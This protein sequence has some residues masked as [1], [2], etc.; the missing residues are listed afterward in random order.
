MFRASYRAFGLTIASEVELPELPLAAD[1]AAADV[2]IRLGDTPLTLREGNPV[3][4]G[5]SA[6]PG[7]MLID[8][9]AARF[10][11]E[12]GADILVEFKPR[13]SLRDT[14]SYLLGS[15]MGAIIHQRG[16]LPLHANVIDIGGAAVAFA[17]DTGAGKSTLADFFLR[18][19][20]NVLSDDVCVVTFDRTG[21]PMAWPGIP[22]IKLWQDALSVTG[23]SADGLERVFDEQPK[24]SVPLLADPPRAPVPLRSVYVLETPELGAASGIRALAGAEA[25]DRIRSNIYRFEYATALGKSEIQFSNLVGLL[26]A[27]RIFD[28]SRAWGFDVFES[29]AE[30]LER[31]F[32]K[33][34]QFP[35]ANPSDT[36]SA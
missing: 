17:G 19:G 21:L 25:F 10:L 35:A 4:A 36:M 28:T 32:L 24:Y 31:H 6:K 15:A 26:N 30:G 8:T 3:D 13:G 33:D 5:V 22:R 23:R 20:H 1:G 29:E 11:I 16:L 27:V 7:A 34:R 12:D 18:R 9:D 14:R 2:T